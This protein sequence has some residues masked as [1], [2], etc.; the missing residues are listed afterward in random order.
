LRGQAADHNGALL[1]KLISSYLEDP[2]PELDGESGAGEAEEG[3]LHPSDPRDAVW[4]MLQ[5]IGHPFAA[6]TESVQDAFRKTMMLDQST[7]TPCQVPGAP[8]RLASLFDIIA[9]AEYWLTQV[10]SRPL[11]WVS[12]REDFSDDELQGM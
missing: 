12:P 10:E 5:G 3:K 6:G 8:P 1:E 2:A 7:S 9:F 11:A 4:L